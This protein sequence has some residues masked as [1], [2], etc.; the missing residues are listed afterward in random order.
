MFKGWPGNKSY[1][2]FF[3]CL[4]TFQFQK[5]G[6]SVQPCGLFIDPDHPYL[7]A[8]PDGLVGDDELIEAKCPYKGRT[9]RIKPGR[10]F[11][12]L[13]RKNGHLSLKRSHK[14]FDQVQGQLF[15]C[16][17]RLCHFV[18]YT[19][20]SCKVIRILYD[21]EYCKESLFPKLKSFYD[22]HFIKFLAK[23]L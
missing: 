18:V 7:A 9:K 10:M 17:R 20:V 16:K 11:P 21:E 3:L 15:I 2:T 13:E 12:Y 1:Q 23:R 22:K 19:K 8:S 14:Y 4:R 5:T 6:R